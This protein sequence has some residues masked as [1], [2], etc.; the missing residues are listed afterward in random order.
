MR[1][2]I[3]TSLYRSASCL[4]E[5]HAR[6]TA[7]AR[8]FAGRDY[9]IILVNDGSPDASLEMA[10]GLQAG[11][12]HLRVIDLSR[13]FGHHQALWTGLR[14]ARGEDV[15]L[16]DSDLQE[17]PEWLGRF[18]DCRAATGADVVF[19]VQEVR[20]GR[21]LERWAGWLLFQ[22]FHPLVEI[23]LSENLMTIRLM[24]RRYVQA[25]LGHRE[26]SFIAAGLWALTGF[27]QVPLRVEKQQRRG[28]TTYSLVRRARVFFNG[29]TALSDE[30]LVFPLY[31]G[32]ALL[33]LAL[34]AMAGLPAAQVFFPDLVGPWTCLLISAG[35][36]GGLILLGQGVQ[37]LYLASISRET[38]RRPTAI[39]RHVHETEGKGTRKEIR[40]TPKEIG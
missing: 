19:G 5:F 29:V 9:E 16:I 6:A 32:V 27:L 34:P 40:T 4:G 33:L 31:L 11:D 1:L 14:H 17:A 18:A 21:G 12:R 3:V 7:A 2:S 37:G 28:P 13:N 38:K 15:F 24:S 23:S 35:L 26:V 8:A 36:L 25:L 10:L 20:R 22:L 39:V 30:P